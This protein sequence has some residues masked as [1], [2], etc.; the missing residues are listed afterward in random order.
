MYA[1]T[2]TPP[3]ARL[4][5]ESRPRSPRSFY[6]PSS[7]YPFP[8][9]PSGPSNIASGAPPP[10]SASTAADAAA[11][12]RERENGLQAKRPRDWDSREDLQAQNHKKNASEEMRARM[13]DPYSRRLQS[14]IGAPRQE[15]E[16]YERDRPSAAPST[17]HLASPVPQRTEEMRRADEAYRPSAI[18]HQPAPLST[19]LQQERKDAP[20]A[21][22]RPSLPSMSMVGINGAESR[23]PKREDPEPHKMEVDE[24]QKPSEPAVRRPEEP[25]A[26]KMEVDE[27]YDDDSSDEAKQITAA[28]TSGRDSRASQHSAREPAA[29][30]EPTNGIAVEPTVEATAA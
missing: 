26:R 24:E 12:D 21:S 29:T 28:A 9:E 18:A 23:P 3:A 13:D 8:A 1:R 15:R 7:Q 27:N 30:I 16:R 20:H 19:V 11:R 4:P 10:L 14:P 25:A 17:S 22:S 5:Y 2:A 6:P